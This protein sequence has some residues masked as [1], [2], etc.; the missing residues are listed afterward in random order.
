MVG[1]MS[2]NQNLGEQALNKVAEVA[3]S[4]Q[5]DHAEQVNVEVKTDPLK[6]MQGKLEGVSISGEGMVVKQDLRAEAVG[7]TLDSVAINPLKA[8]LGEIE[9][10]ESLDAQAQIL[11]TEAD[12]NRALASDYLQQKMRRF[13]VNVDGKPIMFSVEQAAIQLPQP[14]QIAINLTLQLQD[15]AAQQISAVAKPCLKE[16]GR[17]ID[18]EILSAT[19]E[20]L[21]L[22]FVTALFKEVVGLLDLRNFEINGSQFQIRDLDI[23]PQ[24]MLL[25]GAVSMEAGSVTEALNQASQQV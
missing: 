5:L 20:G 9:L 18:L 10:V 22:N 19:A 4:S 24:K 16:D 2:Q 23:Q 12:I 17:Q 14:D 15:Q 3:I 8:V 6:M 1:G 13:E 21:S 11:L 25:R 7:I